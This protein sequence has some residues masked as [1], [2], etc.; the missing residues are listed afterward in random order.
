MPNSPTGLAMS[1]DA[2]PRFNCCQCAKRLKSR[3]GSEGKRFTCPKCQTKQV[4]PASVKLPLDVRLSGALLKVEGHLLAIGENKNAQHFAELRAS[5]NHPHLRVVI[6]GEFSRGKSTLINALLGRDVLKA[7]LTPTTGHVTQ[8]S[9]GA[10]EEVRVRMVGGRTETCS[11]D[12]LESFT[13][14]N[15]ENLARDDIE[16]VEVVVNCPLLSNGAVLVDTPGVNDKEAQTRRAE[17][18]ITSADLVLMVLDA[19]QLLNSGERGLAVDWLSKELGKPVV[20]VVNFMNFMLI[21]V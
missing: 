11:L 3:V 13:S 15:H 16:L 2:M 8:I 9:Y 18:A 10:R 12:R 4:V 6:F 1:H 19:R 7:R 14:L 20:V 21:A 5:L 17:H